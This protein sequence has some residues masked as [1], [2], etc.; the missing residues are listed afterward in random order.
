VLKPAAR[1][2]SLPL[3]RGRPGGGLE[4]HIRGNSNSTHIPEPSL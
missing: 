3:V 1:A 2:S 4:N